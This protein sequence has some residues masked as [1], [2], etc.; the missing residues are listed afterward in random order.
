MANQSRGNV[1]PPRYEQY[2]FPARSHIEGIF[3]ELVHTDDHRVVVRATLFFDEKQHPWQALGESPSGEENAVAQAE[4]RAKKRVLLDYLGADAPTVGDY[5]SDPPRPQNTTAAGAPQSQNMLAPAVST[6]AVLCN[7]CRREVRGYRDYT[8]E[9]V[10]AW[11]IRDWGVPLCGSCEKKRKTEQPR[12]PD[13]DN[14]P[15]F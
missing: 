15:I 7:D 13:Y 4:T 10:V 5:V 9:Q 11:R 3:T 2:L 6:S 12:G 14:D 8:T 1:K